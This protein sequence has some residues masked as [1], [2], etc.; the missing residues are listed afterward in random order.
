MNLVKLAITL[1]LLLNVVGFARDIDNVQ[2][3]DL[4]GKQY[5]VYAEL[6]KGKSI[7]VHTNGST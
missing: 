1:F 2:F 4:D 3:T 7:F 5:D 6:A